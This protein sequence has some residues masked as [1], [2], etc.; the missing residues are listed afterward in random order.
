LTV[1]LA[2]VG[3]GAVAILGIAAG[4]LYSEPLIKRLSNN[5]LLAPRHGRIIDANTGQGLPDVIVVRKWFT[6]NLCEAEKATITDTNGSYELPGAEVTFRRTWLFELGLAIVPL[7]L[8][9]PGKFDAGILLYKAGYVPDLRSDNN[10]PDDPH[11]EIPPV[12]MKFESPDS[13]AL[14]QYDW[15]LLQNLSCGYHGATSLPVQHRPHIAGQPVTDADREPD[16]ALLCEGQ[17][18][19]TP[20]DCTYKGHPELVKRAAKELMATNPRPPH[21]TISIGRR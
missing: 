1:K 9:A 6:G 8:Q 7:P 3:L 2:N 18:V 16:Y 19:A 14:N 17:P 12:R 21:G 5:A 4:V 10:V 11:A 15:R 20:F 13:D